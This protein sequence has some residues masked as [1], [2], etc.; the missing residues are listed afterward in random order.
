VTD[1]IWIELP[2]VIALHERQLAEHGGAAGFRDAGLLASAIDRPINLH[3]YSEP[4]ACSLAAS[5]AFGLVKNHGFIDGNKRTGWIVAR[6]FLEANGFAISVTQ[7][8]IVDTVIALASSEL[9]ED[10]LADWFRAHL[11]EPTSLS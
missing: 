6:L 11:T 4:D 9:S 8:E 1:W 10:R 2:T 7:K 5:Y 3:A